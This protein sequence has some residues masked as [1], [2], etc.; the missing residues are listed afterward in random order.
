MKNTLK[1]QHEIVLGALKNIVT[2]QKE[3][4]EQLKIQDS[5]LWKLA[6]EVKASNN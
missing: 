6:R 5:K 4:K 1:S 2:N 3:I